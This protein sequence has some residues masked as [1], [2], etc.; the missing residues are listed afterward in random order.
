[1]RQFVRFLLRDRSSD[2]GDSAV[3][4]LAV[5][6]GERRTIAKVRC[7][8]GAEIAGIKSACSGLTAGR[9]PLGALIERSAAGKALSVADHFLI[10][11]LRRFGTTGRCTG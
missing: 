7:P 1:M 8:L 9:T 10:A 6:M 11:P 2:H 4:M 5:H 3:D